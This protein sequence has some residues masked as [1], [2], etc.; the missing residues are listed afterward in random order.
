MEPLLQDVR[1][2]LRQMRKSPG[3]T[4]VAILSLALGIGANTAIFTLIHALV[5]KSLP[6]RAPQQLVSFG[7]AVDGRMIDGI[8]PGP[9]DVF[10]YDFYKQVEQQ[11]DP[12]QGVSATGS[13]PITV[14]VR[15]GSE[16]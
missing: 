9:L 14:S 1:Y 13:F 15:R 2:A 5:L 3:F 10:P 11:H 7:E 16:S 4:T 8:G 12:F 6:V